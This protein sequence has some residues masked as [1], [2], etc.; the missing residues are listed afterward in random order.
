MNTK[1]TTHMKYIKPAIVALAALMLLA[2]QGCAKKQPSKEQL[3][4]AVLSELPADEAKELPKHVDI[5]VTSAEYVPGKEPGDLSGKVTYRITLKEDFYEADA[6]GTDRLKE[7]LSAVRAKGDDLISA[8]FE[9]GKAPQV[10]V[11]KLLFLKTKKGT[12]MDMFAKITAEKRGDAY[13]ITFRSRPEPVSETQKDLGAPLMA[14]GLA[15]GQYAIN[16]TSESEKVLK[17]YRESL[18]NLETAIIE[19]NKKAEVRREAERKAEEERRKA[20]AARREAARK[21][22][23]ERQ[24]AEQER[25]ARLAREQKELFPSR[26]QPGTVYEGTILC[27]QNMHS[28][29]RF[30]NNEEHLSKVIVTCD[31]YI[32]GDVYY[33]LGTINVLA[34]QHVQ[35]PIKAQIKIKGQVSEGTIRLTVVV[36]DT[37]DKKHCFTF[38]DTRGNFHDVVYSMENSTWQMEIDNYHTHV[39]KLKKATAEAREAISK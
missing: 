39:I 14:L 12:S 5:T 11:P 25:L 36:G 38:W 21:A 16:G 2:L 26:F 27:P 22:E 23:E 20:E 34:D 28:S 19:A 10:T 31:S 13:K 6:K 3:V 7:E 4:T 37:I 9:G 1:S 15:Q 8:D 29:M 18:K 33:V 32:G 24:R 30:N 17:D 35:V